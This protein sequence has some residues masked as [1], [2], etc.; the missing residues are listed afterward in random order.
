MAKPKP[1]YKVVTPCEDLREGRPLDASEFAVH[2]DA[3]RDGHAHADYQDPARFFDR[4]YL[5]RN[6]LSVSAEVQRRLSG[7]RVET[8]AVYNMTTQFGG[9]KTHA[10]ALFYHMAT[11]G[12]RA[13]AFTG[14]PAILSK[15][16]IPT[17]PEANVG[18]FV[19]TRFD[20]LRGCGGDDGTPL[21]RTPWGDL[22]W[23]IG[24]Q[25]SFDVVREHDEKGIA[26]AGD[27]IRA[28]IPSDKPALFLIDEVMNY[29]STSRR[30]GLAGQMYSFLMAL[31]E[32]I[33]G[34]DRV[35][36][37]VSIPASELEMSA[38]DEGDYTRLKKM[39]DR[40]AK[41]VI[42]SAENETSE[43]IRRRLFEWDPRA[44][45]SEGRVLLPADA[46][47]A[48]REYA[49]WVR[50]HR[51]QVPNWF[52]DHAQAAFEACYPLHPMVLSVF[53]RKWCELPRFQQTR[54]ILRLLALWVSD[55]YQSGFRGAD[56]DLLITLGTAPLGDSQFRTA[57]FE[58]LG[59]SRLEGAVT[60]DL[61]GKRESQ[62]V[63]LD[64]EAEETL[65]KAKV[66]QKAATAVFFES[67]GG[68]GK[69]R[70]AATLPE[71]RLAV[72]GPD[73]DI[74][75]VETALEGL[76][77]RCYYLALDRNQYFFSLKQNLNKRFADRRA[78]VKPEDVD[79][80]VRSQIEKV[81]PAAAGIERIFFPE[82]S[83]QVP[84]RAVVTFAVMAPA[85][86]LRDEP[87]VALRVLDMTRRCGSTDRH[88]K[89]ALI[90][91]VPEQT[92]AMGDEARKLLAWEA[93][94][95]ETNPDELDEAQK[96]QLAENI[97]RGHRDLRESVW[98]SYNKV[99]LLDPTNQ[100]KTIDLGLITSS[101]AES[102]TA[103]VLSQLRQ[104]DEIVKAVSPRFLVK[105][106]PPAKAEWSIRDVRDAFFASPLFPRLLSADAVNAV[107]ARGVS[108]GQFAYVG[109]KNDGTYDPFIY[110]QPL[111]ELQVEM[112][113]DLFIISAQEAE[114]HIQPPALAKVTV[115]PP[116][117][118]LK[119][120]QK[121]TFTV[122]GVDQFG[123][124]MAIAGP[125]AWTATGGSVDDQG[126]LQVTGGEG[127]YIVTA[128]VGGVTG[129]AEVTIAVD[130]HTQPPPPA[131]PR[132]AS[133]RWSG[134]IP[135]QKWMNFYTKVLTKLVASGG[136][137]ITV[138]VQASP[139]GGLADRQV[140]DVKTALRG[141]G[142]NDS[143]DVE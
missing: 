30:T 5:T 113:P 123:K 44:V 142:L 1:W 111:S 37:V 98:R 54:G 12:D 77:G 96:R 62:A 124:D 21:R 128:N 40:R 126:V 83:A 61:A 114:R 115:M 138:S 101:S 51:N 58:Q 88:F 41:P 53:E 18:V 137:K 103:L 31:S 45:S 136:L 97:K 3:I 89:S 87:D 50:D 119:P 70:Q 122:N 17:V 93:I 13:K 27:V 9:G 79:R 86:A 118:R 16:Q 11:S 55:A 76:V 59:E 6:L 48:C 38:E 26:P 74:G 46:L 100:L 63:R 8:S 67:N 49:D 84:N 135:A 105:N 139:A 102:M 134:E 73:I 15:A 20:V 91:I 34:M 81:F 95:A 78:T 75:N 69:A 22:A 80:L 127:N 29:V 39:L 109:K 32:E 133:L 56:K 43:I 117:A 14:V 66:H 129:R 64:A 108:E 25:A 19:G 57:V 33:V 92:E 90:W 2:I 42:M 112:S 110:K 68:Q 99:M 47:A 10:L 85:H 107:I 82:Q 52:A 36:A 71:V 141:L 104:G 72:A 125:V 143:V 121:Q 132:D 65:R 4:T 7:I 24:G 131:P 35:V 60:T 106:W 23:Q 120:G 130:D 116:R 94:D 140:E 28:M